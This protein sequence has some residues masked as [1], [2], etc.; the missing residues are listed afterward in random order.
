MSFY[1]IL[2]VKLAV[3]S[4]LNQQVIRMI[5]KV[6]RSFIRMKVVEVVL[7]NKD[8]VQCHANLLF[9]VPILYISRDIACST[10]KNFNVTV[11][12]RYIQ[13]FIF[14]AVFATQSYKRKRM[15]KL[16]YYTY[17]YLHHNAR[18][19]SEFR[20]ISHRHPIRP[21]TKV[22]RFQN[23]LLL[24]ALIR[25][26]QLLPSVSAARTKTCG[27]NG[28]CERSQQGLTEITSG[29]MQNQSTQQNLGISTKTCVKRI[30]LFYIVIRI[31][32]LITYRVWKR[33]KFIRNDRALNPNKILLYIIIL[34]SNS[35]YFWRLGLT[36]KTISHLL[37]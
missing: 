3:N 37:L 11:G 18:S 15:S 31:K 26:Q 7:R 17:L 36:I 30:H 13:S 5:A 33:S 1:I 24:L 29:R 22:Q 28:S 34:F 32:W 14:P 20:L 21:R 6:R 35:S 10:L 23:I 9:L 16:L 2:K 27:I 12:I 4:K 19:S 8:R 25:A